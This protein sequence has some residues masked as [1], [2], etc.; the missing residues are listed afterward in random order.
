MTASTRKVDKVI[1]AV[2]CGHLRS[3]MRSFG[4]CHMIKSLHI[5]LERTKAI[6]PERR[7]VGATLTG[8]ARSFLCNFSKIYDFQEV[9]KNDR[10]KL[11]QNTNFRNRFPTDCRPQ[12]GAFL[13]AIL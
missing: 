12:N 8:V 11:V 5:P 3:F 7:A 10:G 13:V 2:V 4:N 1:H 6:A 9:D